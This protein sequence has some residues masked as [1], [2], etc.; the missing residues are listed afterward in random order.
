MVNLIVY[1]I[2]FLI[3]FV[4]FISVFLHS[5][6]KNLK[7][8]GFAYLYKT[9]WGME[10]IDYIGGKHQKTLKFLS[11]ISITLGYILMVSA[12]YFIG[13]L[14]WIYAFFPNV[15]QAIK[16]PPITPLI[17][18]IDKVI[19]SS[20]GF[21]PFYAIYFIIILAI[22]AIPH[23]FAHGIFMKR[24]NIKIHST[25]FGFFPTFFPV[26][27]LA[28][29]E[30]DEKS[31]VKASKFKQ[32]AVLSAG[33]FANI[34]TAILFFG[35]IWVFFSL[36]F[37]PAGVI[38]ND[39]SYSVVGL[40]SITM[41]NGVPLENPTFEKIKELSEEDGFNDIEAGGRTYKGFKE[42]S[43]D[44]TKVALYDDSPAINS[45]LS[46]AINK[47]NGIRV[48]SIDELGK[49]LS[50][51]PPGE[52]IIITTIVDGKTSE[53]DI[54][55]GENPYIPKKSW[56]GV[57][58]FQ[59]AGGSNFR[60][61]DPLLPFKD[62]HTFYESKIGG[63]GQFILDLLGLIILITISVAVL[64]MLPVG[65]F[66]G[67]RF[68]YLTIWGLTRSESKARKA[69][70]FMTYL[71]LALVGLMMLFWALSFIR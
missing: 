18:Y 7:K 27:L 15:V 61:Y 42:F 10:L 54:I 17:P 48:N 1:D 70:G 45:E 31:M 25:G 16:I 29:V 22:I 62:P 69:F 44:G 37:S 30:Q 33:T 68:F 41:I 9:K 56:L 57:G 46:G 13:R 12:T 66:D 51:Y 55:L 50:K 23:E 59:R 67:G 38:F 36:A 26:F 63:F 65:I 4:I 14:V 3:L 58:F 2:I 43:Q 19:P 21:P 52:R 35:I 20:L 60:I 39:Y 71:F 28:F 47:I 53:K 11:Y 8:E 6:R 49:E 24:Y 64:N 32:M 40:S 34:L 5:R